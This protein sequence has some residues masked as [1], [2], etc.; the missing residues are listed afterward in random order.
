MQLILLPCT[1]VTSI[2]TCL[3]KCQGLLICTYTLA[4]ELIARLK[5]ALT[6][7]GRQGTPNPEAYQDK[8]IARLNLV[9]GG[10]CLLGVGSMEALFLWRLH[11]CRHAKLSW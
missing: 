7:P 4:P 10:L 8:R 5:G 11:L 2:V 1:S 6:P 3:A 9:I